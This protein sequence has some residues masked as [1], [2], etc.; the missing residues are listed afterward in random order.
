MP[1]DARDGGGRWHC[2]ARCPSQPT[3]AAGVVLNQIETE[4]KLLILNHRSSLAGKRGSWRLGDVQGKLL[5]RNFYITCVPQ[6][7]FLG[8]VQLEK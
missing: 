7:S 3:A 4:E 5:Q 1:K 2:P 6:W 8:L